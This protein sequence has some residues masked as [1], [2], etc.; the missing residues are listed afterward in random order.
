MK[1][2]HYLKYLKKE[3]FLIKKLGVV[4]FLLIFQSWN[5]VNYAKIIIPVIIAIVGI[6]IISAINF[7]SSN[8]EPFIGEDRVEDIVEDTQNNELTK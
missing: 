3:W 2:Y 7:E 5:S 6:T 4:R 1:N 8:N